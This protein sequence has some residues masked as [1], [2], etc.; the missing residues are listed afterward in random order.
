MSARLRSA[1]LSVPALITALLV[2]VG[3]APKQPP[4]QGAAQPGEAIVKGPYVLGYTM[5][6]IDGTPQDLAEYKGK[7]VLI[8]NVASNCGLTPQYKDL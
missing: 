3:L 7:V 8:V 5:K 2:A 6:R 1:V 4:A